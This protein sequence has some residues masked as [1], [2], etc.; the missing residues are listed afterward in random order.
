MSENTQARRGSPA[1]GAAARSGSPESWPDQ[2]P[3]LGRR[4]RAIR[5]R[6]DLPLAQVAEATGMSGSFVSLVEIGKS[7]ITITRLM[8]LVD[9]YGVSITEVLEPETSD[10][11]V[12]RSD[13]RP[14]MWS[15]N[16]GIEVHLLAPDTTREMTPVLVIYQPGGELAEPTRLPRDEWVLV[17]EGSIW[18][19]LEDMEPIHL[20]EGD[21]AYYV[22]TRVVSFE[23]RGDLPARMIACTTRPRV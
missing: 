11:V 16:E 20:E 14:H 4:L 1:K 6:L 3:Q 10:N 2:Q 21:S 19:Q 17:V 8:R 5:T 23:N 18:I 9:F 15:A 7:D 22:G 13:A 12:V